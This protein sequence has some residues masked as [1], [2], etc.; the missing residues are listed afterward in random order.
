MK[1]IFLI[2]SLLVSAFAFGQAGYVNIFAKYHWDG[3][4]FRRLGIPAG[5]SAQFLSGQ[6]QRQGA[7]Y[8]DTVNTPASPNGFYIYEDPTG[9]NAP[10]WNLQTNEEICQNRL[11]SEWNVSW[12][13]VGFNF[14]VHGGLTNGQGTYQIGCSFY[15]ADSATV[16]FPAADPD[17]DRID[18]I[19][20]DATGV[21]TREGELAAPGTAVRPTVDADE[22]LLTE[23]L[24]AAGATS[25][26][27]ITQLIVYNENTESVVTNTG[28]TTNGANATFVFTGSLSTNV[29]SIN[30]NDV[31]YFTKVPDLSTWNVLGFDGLSLAIQLKAIMPTNANIG[32]AL[33]VG[34]TTV[35]TEVIVPLVKTNTSSYQQI[36]IPLSAFGNMSNQSITR[37]R[38]RYIRSGNNAQYTGFYL[39][40]IY[41]INGL[42]T[43]PS[44]QATFTFNPPT[45][46]QV[47]PTNTQQSPGTWTMSYAPGALPGQYYTREGWVTLPDFVDTVSTLDGR[48]KVADGGVVDGNELFLQVVDANF[49]G[50]MTSAMFNRLDSNYYIGNW[51]NLDTLAILDSVS[52]NITRIKSIGC[53]GCDSIQ[54]SDTTV[55]FH[56]PSGGSSLFPTTGTGTATGAVI[57]EIGAN[58]LEIESGVN[59][60]AEFSSAAISLYGGAPGSGSVLSLQSTAALFGIDGSVFATIGMQDIA[61][62]AQ[63]TIDGDNVNVNGAA[64]IVLNSPSYIFSQTLTPASAAA[65]GVAGQFAWDANF[66]YIATGTNTWK[67]VSISTW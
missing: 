2:L 60:V 62:V 1:K 29:T 49:P 39:D 50:L 6:A 54:T 37:V 59:T 52:P 64:N 27:T 30:H 21:H 5:D 3:G 20:L 46:F 48:S 63:I 41:F 24:V 25:P 45:G 10:F 28:T 34:T 12:Q 35:G 51:G 13:G 14:S 4:L 57:G 23:V 43:G 56:V 40:Y 47:T 11:I 65:T 26:T 15:T 55:I 19:Y 16:T 33:Q 67:R 36:S 53:V 58:T 42:S 38:F 7:V 17:D 22:I 9:G 32:V 31:I 8:M 18:I 44:P 61:G 66:I